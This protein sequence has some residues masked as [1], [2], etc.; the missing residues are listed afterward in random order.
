MHLGSMISLPALILLIP[1][2]EN[3]LDIWLK[4]KLVLLTFRELK[5]FPKYLRGIIHKIF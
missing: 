1:R 2:G 5:H 4:P 3:M